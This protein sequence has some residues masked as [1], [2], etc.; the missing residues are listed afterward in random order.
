M[1]MERFNVTIDI[2]MPCGPDSGLRADAVSSRLKMS[3]RHSDCKQ[4]E[5]IGT[6]QY[7]KR[8]LGQDNII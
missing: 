8:I 1:T 3:A 6:G 2:I 5:N 4:K 7:R